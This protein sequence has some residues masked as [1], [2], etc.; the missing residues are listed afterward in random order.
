MKQII[1]EVT[2]RGELIEAY[3]QTPESESATPTE[4]MAAFT[5]AHAVSM[6]LRRGSSGYSENSG[7]LEKS[8][9]EMLREAMIGHDISQSEDK[10]DLSNPFDNT[11]N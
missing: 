5:I 11:G 2:Q 8:R 6:V 10:S 4:K 9:E 1:I 7:D 3:I